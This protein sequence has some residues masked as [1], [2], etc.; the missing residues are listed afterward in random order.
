MNS[1]TKGCI[2]N[3]TLH[4]REDIAVYPS[5]SNYMKSVF[6]KKCFKINLV[7]NIHTNRLCVNRIS[8]KG[9]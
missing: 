3:G 4:D 6:S 9:G 5:P 2:S 8:F 1:F 7:M